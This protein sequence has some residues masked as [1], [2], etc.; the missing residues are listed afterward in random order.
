V[1][2]FLAALFLVLPASLFAQSNASLTGRV[3]N[4]RSLP[5]SGVNVRV[6]NSEVAVQTD[7]E[8]FYSL[9]VSLSKAVVVYSRVGYKTVSLELGLIAGQTSRQDV[10]LIPDLRTLDEVRIKGDVSNMTNLAD[11]DPS[12]LK[13]LPSASGNFESI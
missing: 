6:L 1:R 10:V 7:K 4:E 2:Y 13:S 5:L 3:V 9:S 11:I 8:G 12:Q